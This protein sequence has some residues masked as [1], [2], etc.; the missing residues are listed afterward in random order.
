MM[1]IHQNRKSFKKILYYLYDSF[2]DS[3]D[4]DL[5]LD[6]M[7]EFFLLFHDLIFYNHILWEELEFRDVVLKRK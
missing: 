7:I 4:L 5:Y 1:F 6:K 2:E 3:K